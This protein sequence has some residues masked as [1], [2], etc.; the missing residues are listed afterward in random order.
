MD[1]N[2][3]RSSR[4]QDIRTDLD[5]KSRIFPSVYVLVSQKDWA[6]AVV[7]IV[8]VDPLFWGIGARRPVVNREELMTDTG[9]N[10]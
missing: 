5:R 8:R 9:A 1:A 6:T 4:G 2:P 10:A 3:N 7:H